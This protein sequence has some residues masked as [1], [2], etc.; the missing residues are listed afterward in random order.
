MTM[1][2]PGFLHGLDLGRAFYTEVGRPLI[3]RVVAPDAYA[4]GFMG[5]GSDVLGFDTETSTDHNWGPRFQVFLDDGAFATA[6]PLIDAAL[7]EGLPHSFQGYRTSFPDPDPVEGESDPTLVPTDG[8]VNHL[9]EIHTVNE[10]CRS[11]L[12]VDARKEM[13]LADWLVFPEQRLLELTSGEV[14]HDPSGELRHL[15]ERLAA[16]PRDVW[17]YRMACQ[18]QRLAQEETFAGRSAEV[19]DVLGMRIAAARTVRDLMRLC[20]LI[21]RRYAPYGKW[22]GSAFSLLACA[23][24]LQPPLTAALAAWTRW[25]RFRQEFVGFEQTIE[26]LHED[27]VWL[28]ERFAKREEGI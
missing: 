2:A 23:S 15:R 28:R 27:V 20:F 9:V 4:A 12:G 6:A 19:G 3:E 18:W 16:Y 7:R 14:F 26:E 21:E 5:R 25:R 11:S 24:R 1:G 13:K 22:L 17:L 8:P 10:F